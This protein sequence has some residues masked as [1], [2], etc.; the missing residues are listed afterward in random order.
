MAIGDRI[1]QARKEVG[2]TQDEL[3]DRIGVKMRQVQNYE[4]GESDPYRKLSRIAEATGKPREWFYGDDVSE[5]DAAGVAARLDQV[6]ATL[7]E[8]L[9]ELRGQRAS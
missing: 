5:Q 2:L 4:S 3:A 6:E 1:Q 7:E 9:R 8:I